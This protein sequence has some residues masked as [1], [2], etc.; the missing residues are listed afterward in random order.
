MQLHLAN[1]LRTK[2]Q[3][4]GNR[5]YIS[6]LTILLVVSGFVITWKIW[7][8]E[9]STL[10]TCTAPR[11]R[12]EWRALEPSEQQQY[13]DGV[14]CLMR[15]PS[16]STTGSTRY[17]DFA[18]LHATVGPMTHYAA[19]FLPWHRYFTHTFEKALAE[20]CRFS[21]TLVYV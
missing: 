4:R 8:V 21:G 5:F 16:I 10:T 9:T 13:I 14:L 6:L 15:K 3:I 11:R 20:E 1:I 19:S 17:D 12:K 18:S 7:P 2:Q